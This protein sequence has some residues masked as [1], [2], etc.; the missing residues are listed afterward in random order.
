MVGCH[1]N[2]LYGDWNIEN[3]IGLALIL[4]DDHIWAQW[5]DSEKKVIQVYQHALSFK[6]NNTL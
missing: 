1:G 4:L 3:Y 6:P 5:R 2:C